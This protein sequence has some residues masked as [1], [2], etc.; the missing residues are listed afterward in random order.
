MPNLKLNK[1]KSGKEICAEVTLTLSSNAA[2][3]TN[4][5]NNFR[6][7][8]LSTNTQGSKLH[9]NFINCFSGNIKL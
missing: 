2:G 3:D 4:D 8:L 9:Q 1:L 7:K 5:K 6:Y